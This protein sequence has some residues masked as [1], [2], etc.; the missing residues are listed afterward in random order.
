ME[1]V[2]SDSIDSEKI[3]QKKTSKQLAVA[4]QDCMELSGA[5]CSGL[6]IFKILRNY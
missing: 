4:V 1:N 6:T 3:K 2:R 5:F